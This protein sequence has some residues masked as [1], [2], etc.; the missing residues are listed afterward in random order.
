M[1]LSSNDLNDRSDGWGHEDNK[2][3]ME[4]LVRPVTESPEERW[5]RS[6]VER[7][8]VQADPEDVAQ[9]LGLSEEEVEEAQ[10]AVEEGLNSVGEEI[11]GHS[12]Y[13]NG[14]YAN[15]NGDTP[16]T[17]VNAEHPETSAYNRKTI[18]VVPGS[19][20]DR[21]SDDLTLGTAAGEKLEEIQAD[22]KE[23]DYAIQVD[24]NDNI[25]HGDSIEEAQDN[26]E[27][28][29]PAGKYGYTIEGGYEGKTPSGGD[30]TVGAAAAAERTEDPGALLEEASDGDGE[31]TQNA[32]NDE[33][34]KDDV[35][36]YAGRSEEEPL[37]GQIEVPEEHRSDYN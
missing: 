30:S 35:T 21:T 33:D 16:D 29:A 18:Q 22:F 13:D 27:T 9:R 12:D 37:D 8:N 31:Y 3:P 23:G 4:D 10:K 26:T 2:E 19:F 6:K 5:A 15:Q 7:V 24:G 14:V 32:I 25:G 28:D 1:V 36:K 11:N 20:S 17:E 34:D